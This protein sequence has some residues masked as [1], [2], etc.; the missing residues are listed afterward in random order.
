MTEYAVHDEKNAAPLRAA[1]VLRSAA[2][3]LL[4]EAEQLDP[5][6]I[7]VGASGSPGAALVAKERIRQITDEGHTK[8]K[9]LSHKGNEL[10]WGAFCYLERA[11]QTK[12]DQDDPSVP[13]NY[14]WPRGT[15]R[16]KQSRM[17]NLVI[18][19]ALVVAE[20]DRLWSEGERP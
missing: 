4:A 9:D 8:A 15:W 5:T 12:K 2:E 17:R 16:P 14:P 10:A 11:A 7:D 19:A 6:T 1:E 20:I 13:G 3:M 18:A